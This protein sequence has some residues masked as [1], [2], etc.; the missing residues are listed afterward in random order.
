MASTGTAELARLS[1]VLRTADKIEQRELQKAMRRL[2][3]PLLKSARQG[4]IQI[5]P[6]HGGLN[7]R[8]AAGRF[9]SQVKLSGKGASVR[10]T[11]AGRSPRA[12]YNRM[13]DGS[14]RHPVY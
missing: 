8:V 2:A 12:D 5:L 6:Y 7:E 13:D 9:T 1:A 11:A 3:R 4:A 14:V 10:I